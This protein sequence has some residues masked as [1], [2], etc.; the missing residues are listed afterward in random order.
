MP[1]PNLN[2]TIATLEEV[3]R[4]DHPADAVLSGRFRA[5]REHGGRDRAF[6]AESVY[7]CCGVNACWMH[8]PMAARRA[9]C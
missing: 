3:L 2:P 7:G 4:F 6:I 8:S 9:S 5:H 1:L